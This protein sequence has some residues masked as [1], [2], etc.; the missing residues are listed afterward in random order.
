MKY[1]RRIGK[2]EAGALVTIILVS[3][4]VSAGSIGLRINEPGR[5]YSIV[6]DIWTREDVDDQSNTQ[7]HSTSIIYDETNTPHVFYITANKELKRSFR[8]RIGWFEDTIDTNVIGRY[9]SAKID[10]DG[11]IHVTYAKKGL[12][13]LC[14]D[15]TGWNE[16]ELVDSSI[17]VKKD[18][19][20][21][22][23]LDSENNP[24]IAYYDEGNKDL[25]LA[26]KSNGIWEVQKIDTRG[27]VGMYCSIVMSSRDVA[28]I[29][30]YDTTN[31][32]LKL[33]MAYSGIVVTKIADSSNNF[34]LYSSIALDSE[35]NPYIV[36]S[37]VNGVK[38]TYLD[39]NDFVSELIDK[40]KTQCFT[41]SI[42]IDGLDVIHVGFSKTMP[43][44]PNLNIDIIYGR[45][46][47]FGW[48][49]ETAVDGT[50]FKDFPYG[51]DLGLDH[52]NRPAM[53]FVNIID[54][55]LEFVFK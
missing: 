16:I 2:I 27:N 5:V 17:L 11:L 18:T 42:V 48:R 40:D 4:L 21:S 33:A 28:F 1:L 44:G 35:D 30:Y 41:P 20:V 7:I 52:N 54:G 45:K 51:I 55:Q 25:K 43:G 22:I 32:D 26:S 36:H 31:E 39:G 6:Q 47:R 14:G 29:S 53:S 38:L 49:F 3:G 37:G 15:E 13:Y 10:S 8:T 23:D 12:M 50:S 9:V 46:T 34:G 24:Q 19:F